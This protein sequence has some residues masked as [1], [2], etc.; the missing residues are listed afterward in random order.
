MSLKYKSSIWRKKI[1]QYNRVTCFVFKEKKFSGVLYC[2]KSAPNGDFTR[3]YGLFLNDRWTFNSPY[4]KVLLIL[5]R[6]ELEITFITE[7]QFLSKITVKCDFLRQSQNTRCSLGFRLFLS[8]LNFVRMKMKIF[9][10]NSI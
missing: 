3:M 2:T 9:R 7:Y 5:V 1:V 8:Q 4:S 6:I 10:Q